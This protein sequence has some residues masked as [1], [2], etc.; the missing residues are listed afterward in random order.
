[1]FIRTLI[2]GFILFAFLHIKHLYCLVTTCAVKIANICTC[3]NEF[4]ASKELKLN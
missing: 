3:K 1:M 2:M 4:V